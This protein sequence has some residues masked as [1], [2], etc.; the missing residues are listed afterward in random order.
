LARL[1]GTPTHP[2]AWP[3]PSHPPARV[4]PRWWGRERASGWGAATRYPNVDGGVYCNEIR[5]V[6]R[7]STQQ[8]AS[9][10][11]RRE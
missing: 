10:V 11:G 5:R 8:R 9:L 3:L 4:D 6:A 2:R 1:T 7:E